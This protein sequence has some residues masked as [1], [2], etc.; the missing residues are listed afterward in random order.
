MNSGIRT[1]EWLCMSAVAF[2]EEIVAV[3]QAPCSS[4]TSHKHPDWNVRDV[5]VPVPYL[6]IACNGAIP[7]SSPRFSKALTGIEGGP[8]IIPLESQCKSWEAHILPCSMA[9]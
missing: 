4:A 2:P 3:H 1:C 6:Q 7:M 9:E 8:A 5:N